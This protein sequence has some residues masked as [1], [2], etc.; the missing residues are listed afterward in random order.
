MAVSLQSV[1]VSTTTGL[2]GRFTFKFDK[3]V[4]QVLVSVNSPE[5]DITAVASVTGDKEVTVRC[6]KSGV[7][8]AGK[9]V[10]VTLLGVT[11]STTAK[12]SKGDG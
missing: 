9:Q 6:F 2:N 10:T 1:D 8:L 4:D 7:P 12:A 3:P 5:I 11:H